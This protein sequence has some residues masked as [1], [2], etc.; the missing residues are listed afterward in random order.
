MEPKTR[1]PRSAPMDWLRILIIIVLIAASFLSRNIVSKPDF[2]LNKGAIASLDK[3]QDQVLALTGA[4]AGASI[5]VSMLPDDYGSSISNELGDIASDLAIVL[6]AIFL[7][8][9][10][11]TVLQYAVFGYLIPFSGILLILYLLN[12]RRASY[13][14]LAAKLLLFSLVLSLTIPI[15]EHVSNL[16]YATYEASINE[17]INEANNT[18]DEYQGVLSSADA[19][20]AAGEADPAAEAETELVTEAETESDSE[21]KQGF[22]SGISSAVT[23]AAS[24]AASAVTGAA[25]TAADA[26]TETISS[27]VDSVANA[28]DRFRNILNRFIEAFAIM[29]VLCC[30]MPI[31]TVLIMVYLTKQIFGLTVNISDSV[32]TIE[33]RHP[34][35]AYAAQARR[36]EQA[37]RERE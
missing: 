17:T 34:D 23:G 27:A 26:V 28:A 33:D 5:L 20:E 12:R 31:A 30:G 24:D 16:I 10:L 13:S 3:K 18:V 35:P 4:A 22:W 32:R 8:K 36:R 11:L 6:S 1:R 21:G 25:S 7:E 15:S 29:L 19:D 2:V 37:K 9:Y 14:R